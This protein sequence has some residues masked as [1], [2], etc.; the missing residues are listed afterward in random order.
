MCSNNKRRSTVVCN[1]CDKEECVPNSEAKAYKYCSK[2]CMKIGYT[3]IKF[4][5]GD[6][7]NNWEIINNLPIR[8]CGRS[9]V[10]VRCT[11]GSEIVKEL[12]IKHVETKN[13]KGCSKCSKFWTS[14]GYQLISGEFLALIISGANKRN[15]EFNITKEYVWD[16]YLKQDK[17]CNLSGLKIEFEPNQVH[18]AK[19][20]NRRKRTASLDRIDSSLGYIEKNV[21]WVHKDVNLIKNKF[22]QEYFIELCKLI[23][24]KN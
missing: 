21:Q 15:I 24:Q 8:K 6:F 23:A 17:K 4:K 3:K 16:L 2:E 19:I 12:P 14:K 5:K 7:I 11:C 18:N 22:K 20:D 9:Y 1:I 13:H 10:E